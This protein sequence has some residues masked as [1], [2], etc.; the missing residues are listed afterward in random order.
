MII[1]KKNRESTVSVRGHAFFSTRSCIFPRI[2]GERSQHFFNCHPATNSS[3]E[4]N[5]TWLLRE[6]IKLVSALYES[7]AY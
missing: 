6:T 4:S 2:G 1:K 3:E 5:L 7:E